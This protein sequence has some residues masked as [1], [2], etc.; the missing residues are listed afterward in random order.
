MQVKD[1]HLEQ[2]VNDLNQMVS[3]KEWTVGQIRFAPDTG[4]VTQPTSRMQV[5][6]DSSGGQTSGLSTNQ[7]NCTSNW[8]YGWPT[9]WPVYEDRY[10]KAFACAKMLMDK[11]LVKLKEIEDFVALVDE[12]VKVL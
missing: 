2:Y 12:L 11:K 8:Q 1:Y 5:N 7:V 3:E 4:H 9:Y 6:A 10:Q